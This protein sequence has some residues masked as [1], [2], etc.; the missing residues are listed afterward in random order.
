MLKYNQHL[1]KLRRFRVSEGRNLDKGLRLDRNEKVDLWPKNFIQQ[2]LKKKPRSFF[3]T[4]PEIFY[5]YQKIAKLNK[6]KTDQVLI[7]SG[8]D[9]GIKNLFHLLTKPGDLVGFFSPTYL[10]YEVYSDIFKVKKFRI[11]Y[12][13]DYKL[14]KED[15]IKFFKLKPKILFVPNPNQPIESSLDCNDLE[16]LA[17]QCQVKKCFLVLDEAYYYLGAKTGIPLIKKY[18]NVVVLR[19]LSKAFG[20]P[21][22]RTGYTISSEENMKI[23]SKA[24]VAHEL[25][26]ISIAIAEYLLDNFKIVKNYCNKIIESRNSTLKKILEL[27]VEARAQHGNYILINLKTEKKAK[28]VVTYLKSKFI[29]VKGPYKKPWNSC[30]CITVGPKNLMN[31]FLLQFKKVINIL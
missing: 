20:V 14:S 4:Y 16:K 3:S 25:S 31:K 10:M 30:I 7:H 12:S 17:K 13:Q 5:L 1:K 11:N 21:S 15:I 8:I 28:K 9:E 27:G 6:V 26:S 19:T 24:R 2:V 29:Y 22:I 23:L 18:N